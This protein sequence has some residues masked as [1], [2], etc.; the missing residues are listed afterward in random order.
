MS[1][2]LSPTN[3][4]PST[5]VSVFLASCRPLMRAL[6]EIHLR[7]VARDD[8]LG[9][10]AEAREEHLH[11]LGGGIL[12]LIQDDE[13]VVKGTAPHECQGCYLDYTALQVRLELRRIDHLVERVVERPEVGIYLGHHVAWQVPERLAGLD[14]RPGQYDPG[15]LAPVQSLDGQGHGQVRLACARRPDTED[16]LMLADG[17]GISLLVAGLGRDPAPAVR[18]DHIPQHLPP[19]AAVGHLVEALGGLRGRVVPLFGEP[20][21]AIEDGLGPLHGRLGTAQDDLIPPHDDLA[22]DEL[23][24]PPQDGV[25]VSEDLERPAWRYD[26]LDFYLAAGCGFRVASFSGS[27]FSSAQHR[28]PKTSAAAF[29][30]SASSAFLI[31][32]TC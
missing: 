3:D 18:E 26:E 17:I 21:E 27:G 19:A 1:S 6:R 20:D 23:L 8:H 4:T 2:R 28:D 30:P 22:L 7:Y 29:A 15:H 9:A 31:P 5:P 16:N 24:D 14:S 32:G 13:R 25:T 11:L 10:E 12:R